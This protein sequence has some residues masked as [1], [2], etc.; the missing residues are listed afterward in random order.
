MIWRHPKVEDHRLRLRPPGSPGPCLGLIL[1]NKLLECLKVNVL[2]SL[3]SRRFCLFTPTITTIA[4][5]PS[6]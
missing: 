5:D 4:L 3:L 1:V 2:E 6:G